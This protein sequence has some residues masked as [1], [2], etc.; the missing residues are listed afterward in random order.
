FDLATLG[1]RQVLRAL[2]LGVAGGGLAACAGESGGPATSTSSTATTTA[3]SGEIPEE[4][5]GPYPGDG[6]NGPNVLEES[7]IVRSDIRA[8][9]GTAT[10]WGQGGPMGLGR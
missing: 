8:S 3:G 5:A 6:S 10:G 2:G 4:T 7:G 9:F 1:R